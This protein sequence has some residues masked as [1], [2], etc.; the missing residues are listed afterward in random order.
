MARMDHKGGLMTELSQSACHIFGL[1]LSICRMN[2]LMPTQQNGLWSREG[3]PTD[4]FEMEI[5]LGG[6]VY[7]LA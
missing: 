5:T 4:V 1:V 6:R 7:H 3:D 2:E